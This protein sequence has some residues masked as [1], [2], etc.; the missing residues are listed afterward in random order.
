MN[1]YLNTYQVILLLLYLYMNDLCKTTSNTLRIEVRKMVQP[2]PPNHMSYKR[3]IYN[4]L[5]GISDKDIMGTS[6]S[7]TSPLQYTTCH[8]SWSRWIIVVAG[9]ASS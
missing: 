3:I 1:I 8:I 2:I 7:R 9:K 4:F 6:R 5:P